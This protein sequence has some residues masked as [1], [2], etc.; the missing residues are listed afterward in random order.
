[1]ADSFAHEFSE[2][3]TDPDLNAWYDNGGSEVADKC[4][5]MYSVCVNLS[6]GSW[7]LQEEWSNSASACVQQQPPQ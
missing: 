3:I 1:L 5:F 4:S 6:T 7:Q 2:T